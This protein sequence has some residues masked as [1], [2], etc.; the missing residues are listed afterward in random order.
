MFIS[1]LKQQGRVP[2]KS[3]IFLLTKQNSVPSYGQIPQNT[4]PIGANAQRVPR[5]AP[6]GTFAGNTLRYPMAPL[7]PESNRH[8]NNTLEMLQCWGAL[9]DKLTNYQSSVCFPFDPVLA[10]SAD[11]HVPA[12][13]MCSILTICTFHFILIIIIFRQ[14]YLHGSKTKLF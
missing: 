3:A 10:I 2:T 13:A 9:S 7:L 11:D 1:V 12:V 4:F 8:N 6:T 5:K 14:S